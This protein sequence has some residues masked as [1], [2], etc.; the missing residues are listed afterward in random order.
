[1]TSMLKAVLRRNGT[2][3]FVPQRVHSILLS[4]PTEAIRLF[5]KPLTN[6]VPQLGQGCFMNPPKRASDAQPP[7]RRNGNA[8]RCSGEAARKRSM[9]SAAIGPAA[10]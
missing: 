9:K 6:G 10:A 8:R 3:T 1:M 5:L 4:G 2:P 7:N